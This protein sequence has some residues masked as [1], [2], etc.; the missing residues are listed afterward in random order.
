MAGFQPVCGSFVFFL[1]VTFASGFN[2]EMQMP[3]KAISG[4]STAEISVIGSTLNC[5]EQR[6]S[7]KE[8]AAECYDRSLNTGCPGFYTDTNQNGVCH[9]CHAATSSESKNI[10]L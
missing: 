4:S 5:N 9:V 1:C 6:N 2:P 7:L 8:C 3:Y 10:F